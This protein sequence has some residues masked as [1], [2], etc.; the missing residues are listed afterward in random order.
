M[1]ATSEPIFGD[2]AIIVRV[3]YSSLLFYNFLFFLV[4]RSEPILDDVALVLSQSSVNIQEVS[5]Y[6]KIVGQV[7]PQTKVRI[8]YVKN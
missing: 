7:P 8:S 3:D 2:I 4:G 5:E 1:F 6:M